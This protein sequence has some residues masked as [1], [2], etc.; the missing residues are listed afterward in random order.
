MYE[1][2][3]DVRKIACLRA[4]AIGDLIVTLPAIQS[5]K[6]AYPKSEI[7]L[8][9]N[10]WQAD[11]LIPGRSA[12]DRVITIPAIKGLNASVSA[13]KREIAD[14][15]HEVRNEKFDIV[16][17]MQG[18][19]KSANPFV[20]QL[21]ARLTIG[22]I[23]EDTEKTDRY[24]PYFYYQNEILK[25]IELAKLA[26]AESNDLRAVIQVMPQDEFEI[27]AILNEM[28]CADYIVL[29]PFAKDLRRMWPIENYAELA[30]ELV[31]KNVNVV[32]TGSSDDRPMIENLIS[33]VNINVVNAAG[34]L[35]LGGL[36]ALLSKAVLVIGADT[37]PIHLAR[38]VNTPTICFYWAPNL[39]NWG[40]LFCDIH[41][42]LISWE[43]H[44][45]FCGIIPNDPYPYEPQNGC[46][47][48]ISFVRDISVQKVLNTVE[49]LLSG[50]NLPKRSIEKSTIYYES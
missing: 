19:G 28:N 30:S 42:P 48:N 38:A 5:I 22:F 23:S 36:S 9:S 26:G 40:P 6:K 29:H 12:V 44:C 35:S 1:K 21:N 4:N 41:R 49:S 27:T 45:P 15:L 2:L 46:T 25:Y 47:H 43:M 31:R 32:F 33:Q 50:L 7:V 3:K 24:Y 13:D 8:L 18:R 10:K 39:I 11:F 17:A 37:G 16:F 20:N 34:R 14:F